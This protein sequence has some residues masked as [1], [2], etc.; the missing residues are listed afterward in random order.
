[1]LHTGLG[2][3]QTTTPQRVIVGRSYKVVIELLNGKKYESAPELVKPVPLIDAIKDKLV[4]AKDSRGYRTPYFEVTAD[5]QDSP[6][7]GDYY[8][9]DWVNYIYLVFCQNS[10]NNGFPKVLTRTKCC[11]DCWSIQRTYGEINLAND[12]LFNGQ[13][14][15]QL[16]SKVPYNSRR[17]YYIEISLYTISEAA[18]QYWKTVKN[19]TSNVGGIF[20]N[21]PMTISGNIKNIVN[22]EEQVLGFFGASAITKKQIYILR[23]KAI[24][25]PVIP[26]LG[27]SSVVF[28]SGCDGF[29]S[30]NFRT[31]IKPKNWNDDYN[32]IFYE[33]EIEF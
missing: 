12:N 26:S 14:I 5:I 6:A 33:P 10:V 17:P 23:S 13:K 1:L 7:K 15:N 31:P 22:E 21:P 18:H 29:C 20:D 28:T 8:R 9:W 32:V 24:S 4:E 27:A 2:I 11:D 25:S 30:G 16:I 3:Y 19:Q